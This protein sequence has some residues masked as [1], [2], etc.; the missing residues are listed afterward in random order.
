[1]ER[2]IDGYIYIVQEETEH[3]TYIR[4]LNQ[5]GL[6]STPLKGHSEYPPVSLVGTEPST[7]ILSQGNMPPELLSQNIGIKATQRRFSQ[8]GYVCR[9]GGV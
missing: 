4:R 1:M 7:S 5:R 6:M 3:G 8:R 2:M 9:I